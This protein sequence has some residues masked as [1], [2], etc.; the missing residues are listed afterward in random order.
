MHYIL[1]TSLYKA[2]VNRTTILKDNHF[3]NRVFDLSVTFCESLDSV[4]NRL[5]LRQHF[6]SY[7]LF[8]KLTRVIGISFRNPLF[9]NVSFSV[10]GHFSLVST[11][12]CPEQAP[13]PLPNQ[14][15]L[16]SFTFTSEV[17]STPR[18]LLVVP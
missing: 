12:P 15:A 10:I 6:S 14:P 16:L 8:Q 1:Y 2:H 7:I 4:F 3:Q 18:M 5:F 11:E 9:V 17:V 13:Q